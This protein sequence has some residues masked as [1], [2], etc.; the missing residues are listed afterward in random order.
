MA[1]RKR[2]PERNRGFDEPKP[3]GPD[4]VEWGGDLIWA[5]DYTPGGAPI[6]LTVEEFR[7][8]NEEQG[9][10]TGWARAKRVLKELFVLR[11][12]P[13]TEVEVGWVKRIGD[14]LSRDIY[15]A[16]VDLAPDPSRLSGT[17]VALLPRRDAE[18][19]LAE[20]TRKE[21]RLLA[22]LPRAELPFAV[23]ELAG[24][25]PES[26]HVALV[27]RY[28]CG[29]PLD[30]R[31]GRQPS[32]RPG[33]VLGSIMAAIHRLDVTRF[34]DVLPGHATRRAHARA[35]LA[36][37]DGLEAAEAREAFAWAETHLPPDEP[38]VLVHGDLLGQNIL[39]DPNGPPAVI[40]W[41]YAHRGDPAHDL[42]IVT[43]GAKQPFQ[44]NDGLGK[45]LEVYRRNGG[46]AVTRAHV[47][48]HELCLA[49][50]WYREALAGRGI[51]PPEQELMRLSAVLRRAHAAR[52]EV[53]ALASES[54]AMEPP[55]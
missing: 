39:L 34:V 50:N 7:R 47:H 5:V 23:P 43:R 20:R 40:D 1:R 25:L 10:T 45:L 53:P 52:V 49:A 2:G 48:I 8:I 51:H 37:F 55:F 44:V 28:V 29:V 19:R 41:E 16:D 26:G 42:A 24:A 3:E 11:S 36:A 35:A 6:G 31:A 46:A 22:R 18:G 27:R 30:L 21:L 38:G 12:E 13:E 17:F 15:A 9:S 14:G 32:I 4:W 54:T 33:D